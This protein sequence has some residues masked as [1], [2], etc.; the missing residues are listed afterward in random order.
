MQRIAPTPATRSN[1]DDTGQLPVLFESSA[2]AHPAETH[3]RSGPGPDYL[4]IQASQEFQTLRSRFR[5]FVFPMTLLFIL[6]YFAY[7]ILAAYFHDFM[8]RPVIG[9][10]NV[11]ILMG[12]GQFVS[13]ALI[14]AAYVRFAKRRLDPEVEKVRRQAGV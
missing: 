2:P 6:W 13:T 5:R 11:G 7:V 8:S 1:P 10:L 12:A 9:V 14:M 4:A 3:S